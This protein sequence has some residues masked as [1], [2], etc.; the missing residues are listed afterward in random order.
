MDAV[1]T[2]E[3][4]QQLAEVLQDVTKASA[5][6]SE[7]EREAHSQAKES[8]VEARRHAKRHEGLLQIN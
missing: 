4:A 5:G 7:P 2:Q 8:I 3:R 6:L 1:L